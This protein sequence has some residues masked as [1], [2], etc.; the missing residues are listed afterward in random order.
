MDSVFCYR[1][2]E[3]GH[4]TKNCSGTD[5]PSKVISKLIKSNQKLKQ[6]QKSSQTTFPGQCGHVGQLKSSSL[7][8]TMPADMG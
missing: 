8:L 3:D 2:G 4:I 6:N 1:Y 5:N 7:G